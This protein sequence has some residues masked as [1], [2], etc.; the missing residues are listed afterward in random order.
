VISDFAVKKLE[1]VTRIRDNFSPGFLFLGMEES[2]TNLRPLPQRHLH[3]LLSGWPKRS[4]SQLH[5]P[6]ASF[7]LNPGA[8]ASKKKSDS[9]PA[10]DSPLV[11]SGIV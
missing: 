4:T 9:C 1:S 10:K 5:S 3:M 11:S 6:F 2:Q 7:T 8:S